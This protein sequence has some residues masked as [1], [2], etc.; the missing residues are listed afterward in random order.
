M[1]LQVEAKKPR[2]EPQLLSPSGRRNAEC[3][4]RR[5]VD[6]SDGS[7]FY[8]RSVWSHA[9]LKLSGTGPCRTISSH[10]L[11]RGLSPATKE[12]LVILQLLPGAPVI[13]ARQCWR[14][15]G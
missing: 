10:F 15:K 14:H 3:F 6:T 2:G 4:C 13:M 11:R 1:R 8:L 9:R 7:R 5:P 12:L